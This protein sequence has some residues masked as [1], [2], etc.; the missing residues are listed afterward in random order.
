[1]QDQAINI[2][3]EELE[4]G[5]KD[6]YLIFMVDEQ[7]YG[8]EIKY[9][10]EIIGLL[11]ITY[12]PHQQEYI[13]GIVNL[14]GKIIPVVDARIR[15]G[16]EYKEYHERTCIIVVSIADFQVGIIVDHVSEV[17]IIK[18][19]EL[20]P[21]PEVEMQAAERFVKSVANSSG[22]LILLLDC[23]KFVNPNKIGI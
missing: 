6:K 13:K 12:V 5:M 15:L 2:E 1:M 22:R 21:L 10:I 8:I 19:D 16:K 11:P 14:R 20:A 9:V 18:E 7:Y 17:A 23:E 4:E 3:L